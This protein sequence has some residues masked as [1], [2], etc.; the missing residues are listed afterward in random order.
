MGPS[1]THERQMH[2]F[3]IFAPRYAAVSAAMAILIAGAARA[4]AGCADLARSAS[5]STS[6][7]PA[8]VVVREG[9]GSE[10]ASTLGGRVLGAADG[11]TRVETRF[12]I[13]QQ[14]DG[15]GHVCTV[16]DRAEVRVGFEGPVRVDVSPRYRPG[17]CEHEATKAHEM[18]HV[19]LMEAAVRDGASAGRRSL[20]TAAAGWWREGQ[21]GREA[22]TAEVEALLRGVAGR[23]KADV[24]RQI[25]E[26]NLRLDSPSEYRSVLARCTNW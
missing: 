10:G 6:G 14:S 25:R 16:I 2:G 17:S 18:Q 22:A 20:E 12:T 15:A 11:S 9:S 24:D 7:E 3:R 26:R 21:V 19:G 13:R 23:I 5:V 1:M 8:R 4:E